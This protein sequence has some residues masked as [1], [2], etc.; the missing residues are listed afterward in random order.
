MNNALKNRD[1]P[2]LMSDGRHGTDYRPSQFV[3]D[4]IIKQNNL[5]SSHQIR[6]F[7][8][9][10]ANALRQINSDYYRSLNSCNT[11]NYYHVDPNNNDRYWK[12]Y[13]KRIGY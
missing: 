10:N 9:E 12:T 5:T 6:R 8:T 1:C 4:L 2:P 13:N 3:M 11:C 7:L